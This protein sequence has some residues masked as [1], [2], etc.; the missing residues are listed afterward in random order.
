MTDMPEN[1]TETIDLWQLIERGLL[2]DKDPTQEQAIA[3]NYIEEVAESIVSIEK[4]GIAANQRADLILK[5]LRLEGRTDRLWRAGKQAI[6][7]VEDFSD[8]LP[9]GDAKKLTTREK[10][11]RRLTL[12]RAFLGLTDKNDFLT[13]K[14]RLRQLDTLAKRATKSSK[15]L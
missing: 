4:S 8:G 12:F 13:D 1:R 5:A 14:E 15:N 10:S 6:Q 2:R 9:S 7:I 3:L 11:K